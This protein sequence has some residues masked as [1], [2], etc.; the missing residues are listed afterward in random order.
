MTGTLRTALERSITVGTD[1]SDILATLARFLGLRGIATAIARCAKGAIRVN[2][3]GGND[4]KV[5]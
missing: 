2:S 3:N 4:M 5:R 1:T